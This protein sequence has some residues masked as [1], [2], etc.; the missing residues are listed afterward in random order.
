MPWGVAKSLLSTPVVLLALF[1]WLVVASFL[2]WA[3]PFWEAVVTGQSSWSA[4]VA[5]AVFWL[6]LCAFIG[7]SVITTGKSVANLVHGQPL[8]PNVT[9]IALSLPG[10]I[11]LAYGCWFL[12]NV[13]PYVVRGVIQLPS[14]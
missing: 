7:C 3:S 12:V 14:N 4:S 2:F 6:H 9:S 10:L 8:L 11:A 1:G 13:Q 5:D